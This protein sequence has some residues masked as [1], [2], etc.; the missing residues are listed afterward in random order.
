[1]PES[2][3]NKAVC[4]GVFGSN[5]YV[6]LFG[7]IDTSKAYAG[8]HSK[9]WRYDIEADLWELLPNLPD[10]THRIAASA[11]YLNG[12][13]Y[14]VGGY[15][16]LPS[17][18]EISLNFAHRFDCESNQFLSNAAPLP[19]AIDDHVHCL[20]RDSVLL[21]TTGWSNTGNMA[22]V[23]MY[24][25]T[26]D[27][28]TAQNQIWNFSRYSS[29]GASGI[30]VGDTLFYLG[31]AASNFGFPIQPILRKGAIGKD[32]PLDI[33]WSDMDIDLGMT[34]YRSGA[35]SIDGGPTWIGGSNNTYNYDGVAHDGAGG[36]D[37]SAKILQYMNHNLSASECS[38]ASMDLRGLA[39]FPEHGELYVAGGMLEN[40]QIS[41]QLFRL[42]IG[43]LSAKSPDPNNDTFQV[44]PNP[45]SGACVFQSSHLVDLT[46]YT[47]SGAEIEHYCAVSKK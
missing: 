31:G 25:P 34:P 3:S 43:S 37:P 29:F 5:R 16:V 11:N 30:I 38:T 18:N 42:T 41:D 45:T 1:M 33:I 2:V 39:W 23:Q 28:W 6:Y 4:G 14:I 32:N 26:T 8:I 24:N 13:I 40:Q 17:G 47:L 36:V 46:I 15:E 12:I 21:I 19:K 22:L 7:G 9:C 27:H 20:W 10:S 35:I 44:F